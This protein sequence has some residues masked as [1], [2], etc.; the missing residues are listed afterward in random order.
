MLLRLPQRQQD[1]SDIWGDSNTL[2]LSSSSYN[3]IQPIQFNQLDHERR[4]KFIFKSLLIAISVYVASCS[5]LLNFLEPGALSK[6]G[7]L[8]TSGHAAGEEVVRF[9]NLLGK[10]GNQT[11]Q[12]S[13][14]GNQTR[15][16]EDGM[17]TRSFDLFSFVRLFIFSLSCTLT[18]ISMVVAEVCVRFKSHHAS[19]AIQ[20]VSCS[21][22]PF[23]TNHI[24]FM[25]LN[26]SIIIHMC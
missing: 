17:A 13:Q 5:V 20:P 15:E 1:I 4:F 10:S 8:V 14:S 24:P 25:T 7:P 12:V 2:S 19:T 26:L 23:F 6:R 18:A 11:S 16:E 3:F 9:P 21:L 22:L